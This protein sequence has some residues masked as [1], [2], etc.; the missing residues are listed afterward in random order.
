M[1]PS[2]LERM[3]HAAWSLWSHGSMP[4]GAANA[5]AERPASGRT[6]QACC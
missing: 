6:A 4:V 2:R 5:Q 1:K 3:L